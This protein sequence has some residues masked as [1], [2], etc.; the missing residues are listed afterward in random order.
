ML[1]GGKVYNELDYKMKPI[2]TILL[3]WAVVI[4]CVAKPLDISIGNYTPSY[5]LRYLKTHKVIYEHWKSEPTAEQSYNENPYLLLKKS[6]D[7][8][9]LKLVTSKGLVL[10]E[11][12]SLISIMDTDMDHDESTIR[13]KRD[14]ILQEGIGMYVILRDVKK[15][16]MVL[17]DHSGKET[18]LPPHSIALYPTGESETGNI[19]YDK[20]M[21]FTENADIDSQIS[22]GDVSPTWDMDLDYFSTGCG[23][24]I[25]KKDGT[26]YKRIELSKNIVPHHIIMN[27]QGTLLIYHYT[28][29]SSEH[30]VFYNLETASVTFDKADFDDDFYMPEFSKSGDLVM[31]T[32]GNIFDTSNLEKLC[33]ISSYSGRIGLTNRKL[34]YAI[35]RN[36][37]LTGFR[38][39]VVDI[40]TG[41]PIY[42][43]NFPNA[44]INDVDI[45]E[46]GSSFSF[47]L[48]RNDKTTKEFY[49]MKS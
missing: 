27:P 34:G 49:R 9:K 12:D 21:I 47:Q 30:L 42:V 38:I 32:G 48:E 1:S 45:S 39:V 19:L 5:Y 8:G 44:R 22:M 41:D 24:V 14:V 2:Y 18:L 46:D 31:S 20:Y 28:V 25:F 6:P 36:D 17:V 10:W 11:K 33:T 16:R 13:P 7:T 43:E 35:A 29:N 3:F 23:L 40:L 37:Y 15:N 26:E 4:V